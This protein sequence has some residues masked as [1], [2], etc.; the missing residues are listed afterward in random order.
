VV[1]RRRRG[2]VGIDETNV[3]GA[4]GDRILESLDDGEPLAAFLELQHRQRVARMLFDD[5]TRPVGAA[6]EDDD[7]GRTQRRLRPEVLEVCRDGWADPML[8]VVGGNDDRERFH[9][10]DYGRYFRK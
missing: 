6:I 3:L 4:A 8:L 7:E 5:L 10:G 1:R 9:A 2:H